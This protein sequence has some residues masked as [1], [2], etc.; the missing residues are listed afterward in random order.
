M[1]QWTEFRNTNSGSS[2]ESNA[3]YIKNIFQLS[4]VRVEG[5]RESHTC[6]APESCGS[7]ERGGARWRAR[8]TLCARRASSSNA[9]SVCAPPGA[10]R[11]GGIACCFCPPPP[12]ERPTPICLPPTFRFA[13]NPCPFEGVEAR[14]GGPPAPQ[15]MKIRHY[16]VMG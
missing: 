3:V 9:E 6:A 4:T 5:A 7:S 13:P 1:L 11:G 2:R 10:G 12:S 14:G 15:G 8:Y 16:G